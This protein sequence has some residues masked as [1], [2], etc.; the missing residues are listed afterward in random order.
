M[1]VLILVLFIIVRLLPWPMSTDEL[2]ENY[3][4]FTPYKTY[5]YDNALYALQKVKKVDGFDFKMIQVRIYESDT[6]TLIYS[7]YPARA[8]D[9]WGICWESDSYNIWTQSADIGI[10]CYKY[11]DKQWIIDK[12]A[13]RPP[14][15]ISKYDD[16]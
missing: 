10:F 5:S 15:I 13:V 11:D 3:G 14:D 12:T 6:N 9:F 8:M 2:R 1:P 16:R 4:S 7:F